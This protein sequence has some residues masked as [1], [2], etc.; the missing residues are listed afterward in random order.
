MTEL[1]DIPESTDWVGK[2]NI[3]FTEEE[4]GSGLIS[5]E[6][7]PTDPDLD[8]WTSLGEEKQQEFMMNCIIKACE[9][10]SITTDDT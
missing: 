2:L 3:T 9:N 7:D 6:W 10:F 4:D 1:C 5:I 8:Y